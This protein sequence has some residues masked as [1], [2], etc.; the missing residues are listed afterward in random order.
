MGKVPC[1]NAFINNT[2]LQNAFSK[3]NYNFQI[4]R[5]LEV[6]DLTAYSQGNVGRK[7]N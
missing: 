3:R 7:N 4:P 5:G 6:P 2:N 1:R